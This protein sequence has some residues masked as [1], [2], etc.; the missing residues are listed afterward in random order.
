MTDSEFDWLI[1]GR[2]VAL[3]SHVF[4]RDEIIDFARKFDPQPF[5]LDDEAGRASLFG[6]LCASG[7]HTAAV[8]VRLMV[9]HRARER[10]FMEFQHLAVPDY[11]PSPGFE[12]LQWLAPVFPGDCIT[13][14]SVIETVRALRSRPRI[15]L[16]T[17]QNEGVN[18]GGKVVFKIKS[19]MFVTR[20]STS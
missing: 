9:D 11:G 8:W 16:I 14:T 10:A 1:P 2:V 7:W 4:G 6:G 20:P 15:G 19:K 12:A 5:H 13:F 18:Q 17:Y 3:G